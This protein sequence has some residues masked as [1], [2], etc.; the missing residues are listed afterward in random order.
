ML[1]VFAA[2]ELE[3]EHILQR[4]REELSSKSQCVYKCCK[5]TREPHLKRLLCSGRMAMMLWRCSGA[6]TD[7]QHIYRKVRD[8]KK[9]ANA[10]GQA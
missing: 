2:A 7:I 8:Y 4:Q 3:R 1:M 9:S 6:G 5:L 10:R